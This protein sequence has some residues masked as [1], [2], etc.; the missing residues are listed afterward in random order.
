M[1]HANRSAGK[2]DNDNDWT[3]ELDTNHDYW[4][5]GVRAEVARLENMAEIR[6]ASRKDE[7]M[8]RHVPTARRRQQNIRKGL[9]VEQRRDGTVQMR[10]VTVPLELIIL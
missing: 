8:G 9:G 6:R 2:K 5:V 4:S 7:P 1:R 10:P 3:D